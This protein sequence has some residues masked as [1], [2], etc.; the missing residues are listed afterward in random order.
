MSQRTCDSCGEPK[1]LRGGKTCE[2]GHFVCKDCVWKPA[3]FFSGPMKYCPLCE[4]P[5]R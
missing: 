5:I 1:D 4:K 2:S 3:G